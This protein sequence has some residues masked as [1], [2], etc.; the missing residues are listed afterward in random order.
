MVHNCQSKITRTKAQEKLLRTAYILEY[1]NPLQL[2]ILYLA[3]M[4]YASRYLRSLW[5]ESG[6]DCGETLEDTLQ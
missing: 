1:R 4:Y 2:F 3:G 6:V 5:C